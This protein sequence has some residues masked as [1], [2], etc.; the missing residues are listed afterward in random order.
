MTG[1]VGGALLLLWS[2][3][4]C[5]SAVGSDLKL[6]LPFPVAS[7]PLQLSSSLF[8]AS[9]HLPLDAHV[10]NT[11]S[12]GRPKLLADV[13]FPTGAWW[14]NLVL[15][16]GQSA[17]VSMPYVHKILDEKLHVS[18]PFRVVAPRDIEEGFIAQMVVSSQAQTSTLPLAHHVVNFDAFS[19]TVRFSRGQA[20]EFRVYLVRGSPYITMEYTHSRPVLEA[21]DGLQINRFKKLKGLT[22]MNGDAI[23]FATFAAELNN[24]QTWYVYA[25]DK[26]LK[27]KLNDNGQ[28]TS[29]EEFT[30]VLRV[31]LCH[32]AK[33]MA[34]LL[35]SASVY[36]IGGDVAH[37]VDPQDSDKALLEFQWKTK[38]FS[39]FH[40][41]ADEV[42]DEE[43][44]KLLMLAL[45]HHMDVMQ[46]QTDNEPLKKG[47][48]KV[49]SDL[50]YTS[51][52][53]LMEGVFGAVW[54]MKEN[55]PAVEWNY[56]D[57]GL[58][59]D[60]FSDSSDDKQ[61]RLD[62]RVKATEAIL[63]EL[64]I[65]A[66]KYPPPMSPDSY[67]FGKQVSRDA[68]LLL[69]ADTFKQEE[70]KQKLL[71]KVELEIVDWL[72]G[73]NVDHFVYDQTFG[74]VITNDGWND[75][76]ADYGNGYYND[77][78][79]HYGYFVYALAAVRKFDPEFI[80][81]HAQACALI[82]GDFGTPLLNSNTSFFNDLPVRLLFPTARHKD[83]FVGHSYAS[84]LFP[85]EDGKSQESSSEDLN[86]YYALALFSS[87]DEKA[88]EGQGDS[89]YHQYARLL[90]A[91]ELRSVKK[92]WHMSENSK[93]YEPVFSKNAMVGVVGEMSVV[94]NTWFGDRAVY[95]HGINMLPFTPFTS[96][97]LDEEYV[98]REYALL[99][100][101]LPDLDQYDIWRSI[102]VMDHAILNAAEAWDELNNTVKAFDTWS[103]RTNAMF[104][105]ATRPSWFAQK[106]RPALSDPDLDPDDKCFGFPACA[107]AGE[108]GTALM[109]CSTLPGCCPSALG[110]CPQEDPA[111]LPSNACFGEHECA[112][113]GLGCC[114][115]IDGCCEPDPIS[116]TVLGCCK[117]QHPVVANVTHKAVEKTKDAAKCYGE[118]LCEAAKLDCC[119]VPGGCCSGSG[120]KLDCCASETPITALSSTSQSSDA[121]TCQGQPKCG[122]AGLDCCGWEGGCCK[123]DPT[124][125]AKLDCCE[126]EPSSATIPVRSVHGRHED[127][128]DSDDSSSNGNTGSSISRIFI[129]LGGAILLVAIVYAGGLCYRRRGYSNID[130]DMRSLYC[131]GLMV[132]VIAFFI[133]LIVT[134]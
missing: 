69:I 94:Y 18:F 97:L 5:V 70:L 104:W 11:S 27:L 14:T 133:Y 116:G 44:N 72:E 119:G 1:V 30:G 42:T 95:I 8:A 21:K 110:C 109:C 76:Q 66:D 38:S 100:Q 74:G 47:K 51:I 122:A 54:H 63:K 102:V 112:V 132:G 103:S 80:E 79:F 120:V 88:T 4:Q 34:Y 24:G 26:Q 52:R 53:G 57:D 127:G 36:A 60:D 126:D 129:G 55:L 128:V 16:E 115:T 93:I 29:D 125:G 25:S 96:Q 91:T 92:Y 111:L 124:T 98:A 84:G 12:D 15:A 2:Y 73:T 48:N 10:A 17:V 131:A 39:T 45:P 33:V 65:D 90:L 83:W 113:L 105:I 64:P 13:P 78:H 43:K 117:N 87:L 23:P 68:R 59:S 28:V 71:T 108:N 37:S 114:N 61:L 89:S 134:S 41:T 6:Q 7:H 82:M 35:E 22:L 106:N 32:D 62:M 46:V 81:K 20:E 101:D 75:E 50:R 99:S 121:N 56:A 130:G 77:H 86:A 123:P 31:A 85:M 67:N 49:L 40:G 58:F 9:E 3:V 107:T 118:P 19:T